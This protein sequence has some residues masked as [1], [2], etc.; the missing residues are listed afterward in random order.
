MEKK[1]EKLK[2]K[3]QSFIERGDYFKYRGTGG[4]Q[5]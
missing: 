3:Y 5:K 2:S 4:L 1:Q